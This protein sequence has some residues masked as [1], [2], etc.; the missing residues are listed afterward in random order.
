MTGTEP[1]N[2]ATPAPTT[3]TDLPRTG[4]HDRA[5]GGGAYLKPG[6]IGP[7]GQEYRVSGAHWEPNYDRTALIP[8]LE[9]EQGE[10]D[11]VLL[12]VTN[13]VNSRALDECGAG[14]AEEDSLAPVV[15]TTV[16]LIVV[17]VTSRDGGPAKSSI[18]I[19][20]VLRDGRSIWSATTRR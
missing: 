17:P 12:K 16:Y 15:G 20:E 7:R 8:C 3:P 1:T 4:A 9:L 14:G 18:Q 6:A 19:A 11:P 5:Q 13:K 2:A 10:E